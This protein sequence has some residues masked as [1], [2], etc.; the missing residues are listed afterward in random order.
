MSDTPLTDAAANTH[1]E[2]DYVGAFEFVALEDARKIERTLR[3]Q[4]DEHLLSEAAET[5]RADKAEADLAA[6]HV[7]ANNLEAQ[8]TGRHKYVGQDYQFRLD[9]LRAELAAARERHA[10]VCETIHDEQARA[11][12]YA[13][14]TGAALCADAIRVINAAKEGKHE[15]Q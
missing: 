2:G 5:R 14:A 4:L 8:L 11:C 9:K 7:R 6:A 3:R 10:V 1:G 15:V 12:N 13:I